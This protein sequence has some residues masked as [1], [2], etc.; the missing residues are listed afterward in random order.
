M[1][2]LLHVIRLDRHFKTS[3][4]WS[5]SGNYLGLRWLC[6]DPLTCR[7]GIM[8]SLSLTNGR[9]NFTDEPACMKY[10]WDWDG[11]APL[12]CNNGIMHSLAL[13]SGQA[14]VTDERASMHEAYSMHLICT[15][16]L[17]K[18]CAAAPSILVLDN[19]V[20]TFNTILGIGKRGE[21]KKT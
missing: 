13:T 19:C 17:E 3:P 9:A 7:N 11:C 12:T 21:Q 5:G 20:H 8:H 6:I 15:M 18:A 10:N 2:M 14:N 16:S 4:A 1:A